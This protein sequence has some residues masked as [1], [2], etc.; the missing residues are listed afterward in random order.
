MVRA[1]LQLTS[2][3]I[4]YFTR[5]GGPG[6]YRV[7]IDAQALTTVIE[8]EAQ[9]LHMIMIMLLL[10]ILIS[11]WVGFYQ[12]VKQQG[13]LLLRLDR[14]ERQG[15]NIVPKI[16]AENVGEEAEEEPERISIGIVFPSFMF[17]DLGGKMVALTD[18]HGTR[19]LLVHWNFECGFCE[20]IAPELARLETGFQKHG[21]QLALLAYGDRRS[22]R[23]RAAEHGL[24][25]PILLMKDEETPGPFD[26][27]G[28]PTAYLLDEQGRVTKP[29]AVGAEDVL[30]MAREAIG[31]G[32]STGEDPKDQPKRKRLP[33]DRPLTESRIERHGLK[34]GTRAPL[35]RLLDLHGRMISLEEYL[36]R[37]VLLVFS[38]PKCEP[39][40]E[41]GPHLSRLHREH[42]NNGMA[43]ILVGRG[44]A[45]E[46]RRKAE[47]YGFQF[48]VLLQ[49]K[50]NLSKEYGIFATPVAFL[51]GEDGV[52]V[53][54]VAVGT[55]TIVA[56][57]AREGWVE[58]RKGKHEQ[59]FRPDRAH[60]R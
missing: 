29:L 42:G 16:Q 3:S 53:R 8:I 9:F 22:N 15:A 57:L 46:N 52:I 50:W 20:S 28:T 13:R 18:F 24:K 55:D 44:N 38:D 17:P 23:Q 4:V 51:I 34:A 5:E 37:R 43:L 35:F 32:T 30:L 11:L 56:L 54:D 25:C 1:P 41:L 48:P 26:R 10:L 47:E 19:V 59:S 45:E 2:L 12:L 58:E 33:G 7:L 60:Y 21:V 6:R 36:G 49:E 14:L 31:A 27:L 40:D 39:C